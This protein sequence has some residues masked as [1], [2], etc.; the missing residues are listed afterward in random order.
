MGEGDRFGAAAWVRAAV[1]VG[2][3]A[4]Q[5]AGLNFGRRCGGLGCERPALR[6][7]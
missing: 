7:L 5:R 1:V 6:V 3:L 4:E 2:R